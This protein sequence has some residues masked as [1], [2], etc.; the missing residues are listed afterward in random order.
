[1]IPVGT[2]DAQQLTLVR[3]TESG[4]E[5]ERLEDVKFVPLLGGKQGGK[6]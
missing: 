3:M 6:V 4:L 5:M 2:E 1:V